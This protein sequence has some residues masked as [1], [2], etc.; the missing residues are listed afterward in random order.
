MRLDFYETNDSSLDKTFFLLAEK[1]YESGGRTLVV[2]QNDEETAKLNDGL[3][4]FSKKKFIPHGSD[5]D[6]YPADQPVYISTKLQNLNDSTSLVIFNPSSFDY[7]KFF[8]AGFERIIF[9]YKSSDDD[10]KSKIDAIF[11]KFKNLIKTAT[12]LKQ[13]LNGNW[14]SSTI[15]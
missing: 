2:T 6:P 4:T 13:S 11:K 15:F 7:E 5:A 10:F 3:W 1:S 9:L 8:E 12:L 14:T